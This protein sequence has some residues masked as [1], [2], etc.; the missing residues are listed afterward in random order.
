MS[1]SRL[2]DSV[3]VKHEPCPRCHSKDNLARFDDGHAWCF[4]CGYY[5]PPDKRN[6]E[7]KKQ[8]ETPKFDT[9]RMMSWPPDAMRVLPA[10]AKN[11]LKQYGLTE[12]EVI[13]N[14]L[15]WSNLRSQLLFPIYDEDDRMLMF[16]AR[17]FNKML[18]AKWELRGQKSEIIHL[19][20]APEKGDIPAVVLVEDIISA[21]KV[22]RF[23]TAMP[24]FGTNISREQ[25][26]RLLRITPKLLVWLDPDAN[27]VGSNVCA[28]A[29]SYGFEVRSIIAPYDP[30]E[31]SDELIQM[32]LFPSIK[33]GA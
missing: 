28:T 9:G 10:N 19:I 12:D 20:G 23:M 1:F 8:E 14:R 15:Y 17:N 25:M 3:F 11:W 18:Q 30:K 31:C 24:M 26:A 29:A 2:S 22:G 27:D 6:R 13:D 4:G 16:A 7:V 21:I 32:K 5:V 33:E